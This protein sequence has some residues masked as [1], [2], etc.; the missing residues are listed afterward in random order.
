MALLERATLGCMASA[1]GGGDGGS[2][3]GSAAPEYGR[4]LPQG[5]AVGA[6][7]V[8]GGVGAAGGW[9][10]SVQGISA[11]EVSTNG[12]IAMQQQEESGKR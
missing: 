6:A 12:S 8:A 4:M 9:P 11:A 7:G 3:A 2:G 10:E 1:M 5:R